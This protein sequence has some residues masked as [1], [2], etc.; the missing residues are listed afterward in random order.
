MAGFRSARADFGN[1]PPQLLAHD[2]PHFPFKMNFGE[3]QRAVFLFRVGLNGKADSIQMISS[4]RP[5]MEEPLVEALLSWNFSPGMKGGGPAAMYTEQA[6]K[7]DVYHDIAGVVSTG[8][9]GPWSWD[10]PRRAAPGAPAEFQYDQPPVPILTLPAIYPR[11]LLLQGIKGWATIAF[12]IDHLRQ[13]A[14]IP[15][16]GFIEARIRASHRGDDGHLEIFLSPGQG[17]RACW[18]AVKM[19]QIFDLNDE[20]I[21]GD[22]DTEPDSAGAKPLALA[23]IVA[24]PRELDAIPAVRYRLDRPSCRTPPFGPGSPP[25]PW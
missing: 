16:G 17:G 22:D 8:H 3:D 12:T 6:F 7:L 4:T 18:A 9:S 21:E 23:P 10:I 19:K 2:D 15:G 14:S 1:Q 11:D 5:D 20:D 25:A 13:A 24:N